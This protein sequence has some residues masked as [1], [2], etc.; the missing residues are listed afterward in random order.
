MSHWDHEAT[1]TSTNDPKTIKP[2]AVIFN[3]IQ[4]QFFARCSEG[5]AAMLSESRDG[6]ERER[7]GG[8]E[9]ERERKTKNNP[10]TKSQAWNGLLHN[11]TYTCCYFFAWVLLLAGNVGFGRL[12]NPDVTRTCGGLK[13][14]LMSCT[15]QGFDVCNCCM[16]S[17]ALKT[18]QRR[19]LPLSKSK[20]QVQRLQFL[21]PLGP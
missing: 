2:E 12:L 1:T 20:N 8:G 21:A 19:T 11:R 16:F 10:H 14:T 6:R 3:D 17:R 4:I 18:C 5:A 13:K 7:E 9:R 15:N